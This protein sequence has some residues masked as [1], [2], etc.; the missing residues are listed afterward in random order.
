M[1]GARISEEMMEKTRKTGK[2]PRILK[3]VF[4]VF[5]ENVPKKDKEAVY[6]KIRKLLEDQK[7]FIM[8][9]VVGSE[10]INRR[11]GDMSVSKGIGIDTRRKPSKKIAVIDPKKCVGCQRCVEV[12]P[13]SAVQ[14]L[15]ENIF[16]T[17]GMCIGCGIC[18]KECQFGAI[19]IVKRE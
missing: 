17:S 2:I 14:N 8:Y 12:C 11:T 15:E 3:K 16:V 4:V 7:K 9:S 5:G 10:N 6:A 18:K 1:G 19:D 13:E